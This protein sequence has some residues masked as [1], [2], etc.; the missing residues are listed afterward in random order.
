MSMWTGAGSS[1]AHFTSSLTRD[2]YAVLQ[3]MPYLIF[4]QLGEAIA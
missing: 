4:M 3:E 1:F 2:S